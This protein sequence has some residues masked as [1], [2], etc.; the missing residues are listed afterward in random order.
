MTTR[1]DGGFAFPVGYHL[2]RNSADQQDMSLRDYFAA[3]AMAAFIAPFATL[4]KGA[5]KKD[6]DYAEWAYSMADAMLA[7]R[8]KEKT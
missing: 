2:E 7:E 4:E 8:E 1:N 6:T 3:K 5:R